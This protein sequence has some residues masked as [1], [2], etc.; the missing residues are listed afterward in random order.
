M[1]ALSIAVAVV[2]ALLLLPTLSDLLSVGRIAMRRGPKTTARDAH[3]PR[4]LFLVPAHNEE[5]LIEACVR[6]LLQMDYPR[7]DVC[8]VVIADNCTDHTAAL[9][10]RAGAQCLERHNTR[11][12]GK[13]RAIAWAIDLLPVSQYDAVVIVDADTM[14]DAAFAAQLRTVGPLR[15]KAAQGFFDVSNPDE[16]PITRMSAVLALATHHFAYPLKRRAGLNVPLVG[17]GMAIGTDVL[18]QH[19]WHAFSIC[20]DWEMFALL[21]ERGI[22]IEGVPSARIL[23][24]EARSLNQ[25]STQRQ[26]WTAGRLTVLARIGPRLLRSRR[27]GPRQKLDALA[28]L[29]A[30]GPALHLGLVTLLGALTVALALPARELLVVALAASLLRPAVYT[31]A[32]LAVHPAPWRTLLAFAFLPVYVVW[33][34]GTAARAIRMVGDSPWIRTQRHQHGGA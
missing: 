2:A 8:V 23:S 6:S 28:E 10:R 27:I 19:G 11:L 9:A 21:T 31:M 30:P 22:P 15:A 24:Q 12:P 33:R 5:L 14:V 17:N 7:P 4:L 20:E 26:R 16:T 1:I 32:A 25:S 3:A 13:P 34:I 29:T 18:E